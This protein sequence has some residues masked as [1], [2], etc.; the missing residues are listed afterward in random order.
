MGKLLTDVIPRL[1]ELAV[2]GKLKVDTEVVRLQDVEKVWGRSDL[3]GK[4]IVLVP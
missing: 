3:H 1:I 2:Q 4:R